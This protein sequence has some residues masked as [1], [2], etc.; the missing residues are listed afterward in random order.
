[1]IKIGDICPLF[2]S[3]LKNK[4][5]QDIDYIQRFHV[6]DRILIQIFSNDASHAVRAYLYNLVSGVQTVISLSEYE[7]NDTVKM[8]YSTITGLSDSVYTLEVSDASGD[9]QSTSEP[10]LICSD[11]LLL[12]E[13]CLIKYSHKDN[14]SPF[15]NIFWVEETQLFF[16]LRTE[17]GFKPNSYSPKVENEQF[18]N[19][20]QEI[21]ELYSVPYDTFSLSCGNSSGIP[22]WFIQFINRVLCLSDFYVNGVAY[23]RSGNS[24]P[25]VTQISEDS[26]MFWASVLLEKRENNL[27]G[28]GGIP[29]GSSAINLVGFNIKNPKEGEMLQ[30]D[31]SQLAF[32]NTD[33]IEV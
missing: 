21:I 17:G 9:F 28:L 8:Y 29:G 22:Y 1:M 6:N 23:V 11:S 3:P 13:T 33:K 10:F 14:N 31:S 12:E 16:E 26:Q 7:V 2:F 24:V 27:S 5:Q 19:Q 30:Y 15:D 25:E 20:K 4:F 18:R 32:V